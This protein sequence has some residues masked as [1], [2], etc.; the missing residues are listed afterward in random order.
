M[1]SRAW[2]GVPRGALGAV[3][4]A[5]M[6]LLPAAAQANNPVAG[7]KTALMLNGKTAKVL[8]ANG[9][10]V[11]PLKPAKAKGRNVSFPITG[12]K[13][14]PSGAKGKI[15]HGGGLRFRAGGKSLSA[16]SFEISL[17]KARL[18][19]RVGKA[20]VPLLKLNARKAKLTRKG[21]N[22][23]LAGVRGSLTGAAAKALN[24]KLG[25]HLFR[26]GTPVGKATVLVK[27]RSVQVTGGDTR[28]TLDPDAA[29]ALGS[30]G[31]SAA[32]IDPANARPD[33][34]LAFPITG[35]RVNAKTFAGRIGHS[36]GI[37]LSDGSTTVALARFD[38]QIDGAPDLT[39]LV[40]ADRVS[41]LDLDLSGLRASV[42][43]RGTIKLGNVVASL[44]PGGAEALNAAF[45]TTVFSGGFV[46]GTTVTR[47]ETT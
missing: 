11:K 43:G 30:L 5:V 22:T 3:L 26:K 35:G 19:A 1:E 17:N 9:V 47:A 36:G 29:A 40:G 33:G 39:A 7:G 2:S 15:K 20:Q 25:V 28:L 8:A 21:L 44:T 31:I 14:S 18:T 10:S 23:H 12:G 32:P 46:L 34:S 4:V 13:I 16:R 38:I 6:V 45:G 42:S 27:P 41:I 24:K 37:S